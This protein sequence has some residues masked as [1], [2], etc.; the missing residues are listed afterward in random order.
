MKRS[1]L[2]LPAQFRFNARLVCI[3]EIF[4]ESKTTAAAS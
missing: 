3:T 2:V 1:F 4:G